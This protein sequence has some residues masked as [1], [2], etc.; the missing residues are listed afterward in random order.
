MRLTTLERYRSLCV[1]ADDLMARLESLNGMGSP[2]LDGNPQHTNE[3]HGLDEI[4]LQRSRLRRL[5]YKKLKRCQNLL[6][7]IEMFLDTVRD[8]ETRTIIRRKYI[9]GNT[10]QE[11]GA[12][13]HVD[14]SW[15]YRKAMRVF[16]EGVRNYPDVK[17]AEYI[18]SK[19]NKK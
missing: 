14:F 6:I 12:D 3:T 10:W 19:K 2:S 18:K 4:V 17:T 16:G 13:L 11:I 8:P 9:D 7:E 15:C 5:Y 1:E